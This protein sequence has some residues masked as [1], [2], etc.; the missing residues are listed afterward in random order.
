LKVVE[1]VAATAVA[2]PGKRETLPC[3]SGSAPIKP[4]EADTLS[5]GE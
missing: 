1:V 2:I 4:K 5:E 3:T